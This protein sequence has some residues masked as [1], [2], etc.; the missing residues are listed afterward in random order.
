LLKAGIVEPEETAIAR[1]PL[2]KYATISET[3]LS[4]VRTHRKRTY[5][6]AFYISPLRLKPI[7]RVLA[8]MFFI[9]RRRCCR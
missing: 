6:S 3:S 5:E 9:K 8:N 4:N 2:C 1:P 7:V